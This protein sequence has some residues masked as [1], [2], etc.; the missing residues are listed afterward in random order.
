LVSE[1]NTFPTKAQKTGTV[2]F[3]SRFLRK[4][5]VKNKIKKGVAEV[6]VKYA[7]E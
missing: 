7:P 6:A 5:K 4:P 3:R 1:S 2:L